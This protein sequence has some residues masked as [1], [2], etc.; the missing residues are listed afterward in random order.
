[1]TDPL[2]IRELQRK[3]I[4]I[5]TAQQCIKTECQ[6]KSIT[7]ARE[8]SRALFKVLATE[9]HF[10]YRLVCYARKNIRLYFP[11]DCANGH[12]PQDVV[13]IVIEKILTGIRKWNKK[14]IP[15]IKDLVFLSIKSFIRNEKQRKKK[16]VL[17]NINKLK[18]ELNKTSFTHYL[19]E[20]S[21]QD[22][23]DKIFTA[24]FEKIISDLKELLVNDVYASFVLDELLGGVESNIEIAEKLNISVR[25]VENAKKRIRNKANKLIK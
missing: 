24:D 15:D 14:S 19:N 6:Q 7:D 17:V 9:P 10:R 21:R 25:D 8:A 13:H 2:Q 20:C 22:F 5:T 18:F 1:M 4:S 23:N 16:A 3:N 11:S 12:T